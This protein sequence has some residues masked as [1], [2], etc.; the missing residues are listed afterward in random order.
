MV[1]KTV[2]LN[3]YFK[4]KIP[5]HITNFLTNLESEIEKECFPYIPLYHFQNKNKKLY[6]IEV[7]LQL[8]TKYWMY[9][10]PTMVLGIQIPMDTICIFK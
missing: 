8:L 2:L 6:L 3:C 9:A 1:Q 10:M 4:Q 7:I 5:R